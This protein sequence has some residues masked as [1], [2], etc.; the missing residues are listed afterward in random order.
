MAPALCVPGKLP[1]PGPPPNQP[2]NARPLQGT[3]WLPA[4]AS[5]IPGSSPEPT[6]THLR[7]LHTIATW[8]LFCELLLSGP[9]L[10]KG[11]FHQA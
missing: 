1:P 8:L 6:E 11:G 3:C 4:W 2:T 9:A 10:S 7:L 5:H